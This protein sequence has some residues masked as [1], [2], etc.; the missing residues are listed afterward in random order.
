MGRQTDQTGDRMAGAGVQQGDRRT[1]AVTDEDRGPDA[2]FGEQR[3]QHD[4]GLVVHVADR[5][6]QR[7]RSAVAVSVAGVH[8]RRR[9][10]HRGGD[11]VGHAPPEV[12]RSET[13]VQEHQRG[14]G[15]VAD[16][17]LVLDRSTGD[18]D[19]GPLTHALHVVTRA[20][21]RRVTTCRRCPI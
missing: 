3:G 15:V 18:V 19:S 12:D 20:G 21:R 14:T 10:S 17:Q 4:V 11:L 5:P 2:Q 16:R 1:V 9:R 13:L 7:G 6:R 8:E